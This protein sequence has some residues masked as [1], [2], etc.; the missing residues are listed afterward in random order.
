MQEQRFS[1][2]AMPQMLVAIAEKLDAIEAKVDHLTRPQKEQKDEWF[3]LK[4]LCNYL[5]SHPAEQTVYG[6]T[7]T[8]F[9][10]FHKRGQSI[11]FLKSEID[12]WLSQGKKKSLLD[13]QH[14]AEEYVSRKNKKEEGYDI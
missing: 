4:G 14:E 8:N 13:I 7:S 6:W 1:F 5:P 9:I 11:A 12:Q 2:D 10:S 3:N